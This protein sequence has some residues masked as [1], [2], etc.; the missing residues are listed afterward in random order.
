ML[1]QKTQEA[2]QYRVIVEDQNAKYTRLEEKHNF[3]QQRLHEK[4]NKNLLLL[5][6]FCISRIKRLKFTREKKTS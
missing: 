3:L 4:V 5:F 1:Q 6:K 2:A